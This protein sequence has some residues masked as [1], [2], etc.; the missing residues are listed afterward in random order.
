MFIE[1]DMF[2]SV[3][4]VKISMCEEN[5]IITQQNSNLSGKIQ[6]EII[7]VQCTE[8]GSD[9]YTSGAVSQYW[10]PFAAFAVAFGGRMTGTE[11]LCKAWMERS[12]TSWVLYASA[13]VS[14]TYYV[15]IIGFY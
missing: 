4:V 15:Q 2:F 7:Q 10:F 14:G 11:N 3:C 13:P 12:E 1:S 5:Y 6:S 9:G 8:Q